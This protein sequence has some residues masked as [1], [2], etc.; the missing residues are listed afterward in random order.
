MTFPWG[1]DE[2]QASIDFISNATKVVFSSTLEEP[3]S[4]SNTTLVRGDAVGVVKDMKANGSDP[5]STIGSLKLCRSLL[6]AGVVDRFHV[7]MFPVITGATGAER[8]YDGYPDV[9]LEMISSRTFDG[10]TQLVE[11]RPTVL[12][13]PP[14]E[15]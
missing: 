6:A 8:I 3:L 9:A 13:H 10:R 7:V 14:L 2:E 12:E 5:M 11:Y 15:A 4:M 1:D